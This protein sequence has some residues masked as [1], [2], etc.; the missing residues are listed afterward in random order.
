MSEITDEEL[1]E[2]RRLRA[3]DGV[4]FAE[5]FRRAK[6]NNQRRCSMGVIENAMKEVDRLEAEVRRLQQENASA[7]RHH[8]EL[9]EALRA[10]VVAWESYAD[11]EVDRVS[12]K[13]KGITFVGMCEEAHKAKKVLNE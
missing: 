13:K 1:A 3:V 8:N 4:G 5:A 11:D 6:E 7:V 12:G 10:L 2:V 9:F